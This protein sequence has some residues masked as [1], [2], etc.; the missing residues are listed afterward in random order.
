MVVLPNFLIIG[1]P[2][3]GTTSLYF[4]LKQHPEIYM[5]PIKEPHYFSQIENKDHITD[6]DK[7]LSLFKGVKNEKAIGEAST[8][9][10][11]FYKISIPLIKEKLGDKIKIIVILRNP[12][13][14]AWSHYMYYLKLNRKVGPPEEALK[15]SYILND[16]PW[17]VKNPFIEFSFY[18]QPLKYWLNNFKSVKVMLYDDLKNNP[19]KFIKDLYTFLEV[20][21][22]FTPTFEVRNVSGRPRNKLVEKFLNIKLMQSLIPYIPLFIKE[23]MRNLLLKK[24]TIP[25]N[26]KNQ[27]LKY[28]YNDILETS[29]IINRDLSHWLQ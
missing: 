17:K 18:S 13:E 15:P 12:V 25:E 20:D 26:I 22:S 27:L 4:W 19:K 5:S 16:E 3:A 7:Y 24:E 11:H 28:F 29:R 1:V 8:S 2:K 10:F 6:W 14:R 9:Y 21:S 23:P